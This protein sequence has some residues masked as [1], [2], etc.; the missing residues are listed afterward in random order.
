MLEVA[1]DGDCDNPQLIVLIKGGFMNYSIVGAALATSLALAGCGDSGNNNS[2]APPGPTLLATMPVTGISSAVSFSFDLGQV[3]AAASRYYVTDRTNQSVDVVNTTTNTLIAQLQNGFAGCRT[4]PNGP[5]DAT[6][7]PVGGAAVNNDASGPDGLDVVGANLFVGDVNALKVMDKTTGAPVATI[8]IGGASG[9]RADEGCFD[10][11]D[12]IYAI[13]SP[14]ESPPFMTIVDA[15]NF[16]VLATVYFQSAGLEACTFDAATGNFFVNNDG[17]AAN[18]RGELDGYS[19]A[20]FNALKATATA[21]GPGTQYQFPGAAFAANPSPGVPFPGTTVAQPLGNCDPTGLALGPGTDIG[22]MCRQGV[23]GEL[24]TFQILDKT[25]G[26]LVKELNAGG[27][28]Q[29]VFDAVSNRWF[30]SDSRWTADGTS[31]G[32]GSA[33]CPLTPVLAIV[34]GTTRAVITRLNNGNNSHSVAV[35]PGVGGA[36]G[37]VFT[38]FTAPS[39]AGGGQAFPN[40][41]INVFSTN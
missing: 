14:G 36:P 32:G 13:S 15:A 18:P 12:N 37:K 19:A 4:A 39:A 23:A 20:T 29:I 22:I 16:N 17:S 2:S 33:A 24:L 6:C 40:G 26:T 8:A 35:L 3:D 38:P 1:S 34:D 11:V 5:L 27:G 7:L 10:S 21:N 30:L 28:D 9:L 31:C 25:S 41:G